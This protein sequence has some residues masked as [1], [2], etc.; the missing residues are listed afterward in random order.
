MAT[1]DTSDFKK[2]LKI[3]HNTQPFS[4]VEFQHVKP[5]KGNA[6]TRTRIKNLMTGA[7]LEITVRSGEKIEAAEVE[8]KSVTYLYNDGDTFHFMDAK[9]YE[10]F[11][12]QRDVL[13]DS[14]NYLLADTNC[15]VIFWNGRAIAVDI[16]QHMVLKVSHCEPGV[17]GDTATNVNKPATLETGASVNVPLFIN[18]GDTLKIDTT[19]GKYLE[20]VSI[21]NN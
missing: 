4:I 20:R 6:F 11:E 3:I 12:I 7:V 21:G 1:F 8:D 13:G 2:G 15:D 9:N 16:P 17:R 10:Q 19:T 5:G 18:V 14:A